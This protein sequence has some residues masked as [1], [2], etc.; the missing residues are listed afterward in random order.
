[1]AIQRSGRKRAAKHLAIYSVGSTVRQLAGFIMLPIYTSYLTPEDY[2]VVGLLVVMISLFELVLGARLTQSV[3]KY[4]YDAEDDIGRNRVVTT[5]LFLTLSVSIVSAS[6][7]AYFGAP[8]SNLIFGTY[9]YTDHVTLYSVMLL[10]SALE[11]YGISFIRLQERPILFISNSIGK[12]VLQL[13]LNLY[14]VVSL[15]MGAMGVVISTVIASGFFALSYLVYL[16]YHNGTR[17]GAELCKRML[18]FSWPLWLAGIASLYM[19]SSNRYFLRIFSDLGQVGLFELAVKFAAIVGMLIWNPFTQWWQTEKFKIAKEEDGGRETF[20]VV[21]N[22]MACT[23]VLVGFG[24]SIFSGPVIQVMSQEN[25]HAAQ[26]AV[27][28]A[29]YGAIMLK[30]SLFFMLSFLLAERTLIVAYIRYASAVV[31]T[32]L[33]FIFIPRWGF[34]GAAA[35]TLVSNTI[36]LLVYCYASRRVRDINVNLGGY[37]FLVGASAILLIIEN[38][39]SGLVTSLW[40]ALF[41]KSGFCMALFGIIVLFV[42]HDKKLSE[43]VYAAARVVRRKI[44]PTTQ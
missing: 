14:F 20:P 41:I 25:F 34:V 21:F 42:L 12:L 35:A 13:S 23:M 10:T 43:V 3:P 31:L 32:G 27:P 18:A 7:V 9:S 5:A 29:V 17:F 33:Y 4:Y 38:Q 44:R 2:G 40:S 19:G 22:A 26:K 36:V 6:A 37:F 11:A 16:V 15:E 39:V 24:V 30:M 1:M 28:F 8:L